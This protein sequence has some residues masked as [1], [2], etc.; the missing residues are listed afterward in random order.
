MHDLRDAFRA[1][2]ATPVVTA[3]AILS[4]ALG[5]G[6]NT[7]IFSLL[8]SLL[9]RSLPVT[10]PQRLVVVGN[11]GPTS[12]TNPIWEQIR[13]HQDLFDGALATSNSRFNLAE[14]G[15]PDF[16]DGMWVSGSYFDVLGVS[17]LL[18]RTL[19]PSDD[20][21]GGGPDGPV[22][23]IGYSFWQRRFGGAANVIG[24]SI[25]VERVPFTIVG[26][27]PPAFFG[28][29]VG[30]K[31][32]VA[33]P[34]GAEPLIRGKESVLDRRSTWW[35]QAMVRLKPGQSTR[36]AETALRGVQPLI[37]DA[38]TPEDWKEEDKKE[39]LK[40]AFTLEPAATGS[41]FLRTRYQRPLTTIMVVVGLVLLIACANIANLLLAR[42]N[43]R[44]HELSVRV[45]LGASRL[46]IAR[47]LLVESLVLSGAGALVGLVFAQWGSRLLVRQ[48]ST[49]VNTVF[50][51]LSIDWRLLGF[52]AAVAIGTAVLFGTAPALRATRV[53]PNDAIKEQGR[54]IA[55]EGRFGPG[56]VLVVLQVALSLVLVVAAGLFVRTFSSLIGRDLGF[57]REPVLVAN[58][59]AQRLQI[60]PANRPDL[61]E[62][63]RRAA[64]Q[65]PGV[66]SAAASAVTPVSGSSWQFGLDRVNGVAAP[67]EN[68]RA[69]F[70]VN[71]ISPEWFS[72]FSVRMLAGRDFTPADTASSPAVVIVNET[73]ARRF[74]NGRN[75]IGARILFEAS[76]AR[77]EVEREIV[78]YVADSVYRSIR[79][80]VP[81]TVYL[82]IP[83]YR[84]P[85]SG[86]SISVKAVGG[87][88]A[89]LTKSL[90]TALLD[91]N[92]SVTIT[93]R[94]LAEQ[95][96]ASLIQDR[97]VAMLSAFFGG[98][99]L[100][101]AGLGLY[102]V[103]SY[104]VSRR[105]SEIG[106]R[107]AL[108][109]APGRVIRL[110]LRRVGLLVGLGV[111][112]GA[113]VSLWASTFVSA[114]L[115]G[116]QP[117]DPVTLVGAAV[118]LASC[119]AL[120]GW[121]P[122]RRA[123]RIDPARVLRE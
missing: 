5:I 39:Y 36:D 10:E 78:G 38:T 94:P 63:F 17:A 37:R 110:V 15:I 42:A 60:E 59:N 93:L 105:R 122:A 1:L 3:V 58:V 95:V 83:Q 88:P 111:G 84:E 117:R 11:G 77:P 43:A 18:G 102:G 72:T 96:N 40:E 75:P 24:T 48:L 68:N 6:A 54:S 45:A 115:Y 22:A 52:T 103:T 9:L 85:P 27:T 92:R 116:A 100:L 25:T 123:S 31:F 47:Q 46:R 73:F 74:L 79:E 35:L 67:K 7:A 51:D 61:F 57:N 13:G 114:M 86:L 32:E 26:V 97:L 87:S 8:D 109:A 120:A 107:M 4:L 113:A 101:L 81:A 55:G 69:S 20:R 34:L 19:K 80:A 89:L 70:Y 29:E 106:V 33:I 30:R 76:P 108:G 104:A 62:R 121:I 112:V 98:L 41:S 118:V 50:L 91:V 66:A 44:R 2:K 65:V 23:V 21:R 14:S 90:A 82:P 16:V 119:G 12:W 49:S 64:A 53:Q 28:T 99:A 56:N 71:L